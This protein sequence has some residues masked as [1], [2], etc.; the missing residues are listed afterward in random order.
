MAQAV[1]SQSQ[2]GIAWLWEQIFL[3]QKSEQM[4]NCEYMKVLGHNIQNSL[5]KTKMQSN[6]SVKMPLL[7]KLQKLL[8]DSNNR[9]NPTILKT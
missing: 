6:P 7:H 3:P 5:H 8:Y 1:S 4:K 9:A 2:Y